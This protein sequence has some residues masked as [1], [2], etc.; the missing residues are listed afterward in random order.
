MHIEEY[1]KNIDDIDKKIISLLDERLE[2]CKEIGKYKK[3]NNLDVLDAKRE[4]EKIKS[5][6]EDTCKNSDAIIDIYEKIM[7]VSKKVQ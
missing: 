7:D 4:E 2:V 3:E 1:R 6:K 5:I